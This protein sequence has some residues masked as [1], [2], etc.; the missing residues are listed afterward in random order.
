[1][2]LNKSKL[3]KSIQDRGQYTVVPNDLWEKPIKPSAKIVYVF[4]ISQS[5]GWHPGQR[6]IATRTGYSQSTV[7]NALQDLQDTNMLEIISNGVGMR[8]TYII[9]AIE[10]WNF[11]H[12]KKGN[13][14]KGC[15]KN[16]S[17][18]LGAL[19]TN[20][21]ALKTNH[22]RLKNKSRLIRTQEEDPIRKKD[23]PTSPV[24]II[25][26]PKAPQKNKETFTF[27]ECVSK[28]M[29]ENESET[30]YKVQIERFDL[31]FDLFEEN[32]IDPNFIRKADVFK[33][34]HPK[35]LK[36]K[37]DWF[38][39]SWDMQEVQ[40]VEST[41]ISNDPITKLLKTERTCFVAEI[42]AKDMK[43]NDPEL[44]YVEIKAKLDG[45]AKRYLNEEH[46]ESFL[47]G[48]DS[49]IGTEN[50]LLMV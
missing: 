17:G 47:F 45:T 41:R 23:S 25:Q 32:K 21:G 13:E 36:E 16:E 33:Y 6:S 39:S 48:M 29:I 10:E 34:I 3:V 1:M 9:N 35:A 18:D 27:T 31:L 44:S 30:G 8:H 5:D 15:P 7:S 4:I 28:W 42:I 37:Q 22:H 50:G 19:K 43:I 46:Y 2:S 38:D 14:I 26:T 11:D 49:L 12:I 24:Q 40:Y 20:Q